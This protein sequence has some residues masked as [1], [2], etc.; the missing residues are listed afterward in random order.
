MHTVT[1]FVPALFWSAAN[2]DHET[3]PM[4]ALRALLGRGDFCEQ[5]CED[6]QAWLCS[7]FGVAR[8]ADWPA[9]SIALLGI[10]GSP[11]D[12]FW[13]S[14]DPV[15]LQVTRDQLTLLAPEALSITDAEASALCAALNGHFE[16]DHLSFVAP[17]SKRWYLKT[18]TQPRIRTRSLSQAAGRSIDPLLPA[19]EDGLQ[20]HRIFN[21]AQMVLHEHPVNEQRALHGALPIN[22]VWFSGGGILPGASTAFDA[23]IGSSALARG[24]SNLAGI[25][26]VAAL[27][28]VTLADASNV[29]VELREADTA[30]MCLDPGA[31]GRALQKLDQA[32]IAPLAEMLRKGRIRRLVFATVA[33]GRDLRWSASRLNLLR[34]WRS[35]P[36][37]AN[38]PG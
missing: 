25:P 37:L 11:G 18:G 7:Q 19:G 22:S 24:L 17:E 10:G 29:L 28:R 2:L 13:L 20:W 27:D 14:A 21:E 9:A 36:S 30:S 12:D 5:P 23:V 8:Q 34:W 4:P 15:H 33:E 16:A 31:W 35:T 32:W 38:P 26:Y 6:D 1:L 3:P